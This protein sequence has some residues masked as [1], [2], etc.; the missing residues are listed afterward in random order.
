MILTPVYRGTYFNF[1]VHAWSSRVF[2]LAVCGEDKVRH[3][4]VVVQEVGKGRPCLFFN[5]CVVAVFPVLPSSPLPGNIHHSNLLGPIIDFT[6]CR[7]RRERWPYVKTRRWS[8]STSVSA[9]LSTTS[10]NSTTPSSGWRLLGVLNSLFPWTIEHP[11]STQ[12]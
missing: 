8:P 7:S 1:V 10:G 2:L 3:W 5:T 4:F 12:R 9:I 11:L 6:A